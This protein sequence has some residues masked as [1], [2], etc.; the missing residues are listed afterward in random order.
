QATQSDQDRSQALTAYPQDPTIA[1]PQD[2]RAAV[3]WTADAAPV[4]RAPVIAPIPQP[5][6]VQVAP[7]AIPPSTPAQAAPGEVVRGDKL[8][9]LLSNRELTLGMTLLAVMIAFGLGAAHA[10]SP[11]HGKTLVAAYLVGSRGTARHAVF[12]GGMVTFT[13]TISVFALGFV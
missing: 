7:A 10:L 3:E 2:L 11:G 4:K 12:L 6:P 1:P 5:A 13:H 9:Q 8:S